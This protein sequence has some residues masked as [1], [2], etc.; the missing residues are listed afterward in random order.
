MQNKNPIVIGTAVLTVAGIITRIIGFFYRTFL[1]HT[2]GEEGMGIYQLLSPVMALSYAFCIGGLQTAISKYVAYDLA[3]KEKQKPFLYLVSGLLLSLFACGICSFLLIRFCIPISQSY[4]NEIRCAGLIRIFALS[5]PLAGLHGCVNGY[6]YGKK[7]AGIPA[8]SQL[9]E[10][11]ARVGGVYLIYLFSLSVNKSITPGTAMLGILIGEGASALYCFLCMYKDRKEF[12]SFSHTQL[13]YSCQ[14]ILT[15]A[16]PL[17]ASRM[18]LTV[19][20]SIEAINIPK[21]LVAFGYSHTQSLR[22]YGVLCGMA[23]PLLFFPSALTGSIATLLLPYISEQ[24]ARS[25]QRGIQ[26]AILSSV[27]ACLFLGGAFCIF[28][29]ASAPL[30]GTVLFHSDLAAVYIRA[31]S[32]TCPLLYLNN[33]L[34]SILHGL[35]KTMYSFL[36]S[37]LCL[38]IR[39]FFVIMLIPVLGMKAYF[40]GLFISQFLLAIATFLYLFKN[41]FGNKCM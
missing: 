14:K 37:T 28:L 33:I 35:G 17:T 41:G 21:K 18:V 36:I 24:Q 39:L 8:F 26:K 25:N 20:Q 34:G 6:Y 16:A 11:I 23:L 4:L 5:L 32:I 1:S 15:M 31:L 9:F 40:I 27:L 38:C 29:L 22:A 2:I 12:N 30:L 10:Q 13:F 3:K 19:L 7:Q